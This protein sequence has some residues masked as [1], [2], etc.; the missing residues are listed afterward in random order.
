MT[1]LN[2]IEKTPGQYETGIESLAVT[3]PSA[4]RKLV[5]RLQNA[6][7][8]DHPVENFSVIETHISWVILTGQYVYKMKKPVNFGFL[9]FST[10]ERRKYYCHE[11]L[12]LNRRFA[13][14]LYLAV[15]PVYGTHEQPCLDTQDSPPVEYLVKM[16]Q[17]SQSCLLDNIAANKNLSYT[18]VDNMADV[19]AK[20]HLRATSAENDSAYGT[21]KSVH[22]WVEENFQQ[23]LPLQ[24]DQQIIDLLT[25][26]HNWSIRERDRCTELIEARR[27]DGYV[28]ECHGDLHLGNMT[29][30]DDQITAFDCLEFNAEL[31]FIDVINEAAFVMM[32]LQSRGYQHFAWRFINRYLQYTGD[33]SGVSMLRY[34]LAY[35][36]MVRAKVAALRLQQTDVE[37]H[38]EGGQDHT[39]TTYTE[40]A[41]KYSQDYRPILILMHGLSGSGKSTLA[42]QIAEVFGGFQIRSDVERKRL[43]EIDETSLSGSGLDSGIY[44][45][46]ATLQTYAHLMRMASAIVKAGYPAIIDASFLEYSRRAEFRALAD[47]LET[48]CILIDCNAPEPVLR[49][50]VTQRSSSGKDASEANT[51]V[52][53]RQLQTQ[54]LLTDDENKTVISVDTS[55]PL[56]IEALLE[57]LR[58]R[59][60]IQE[61]L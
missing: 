53:E 16:R 46:K 17:F 10:V 38:T 9:D 3:S 55:Q 12:R 4:S 25:A 20:L 41:K 40:L 48:A 30:I 5:K 11:E 1:L 24:N 33:Y 32:D 42:K 59:L 6:A 45:H 21:L 26:L 60:N 54:D 8:Y 50:R 36:A 7:L 37:S 18:H 52:L 39:F 2:P 49:K 27:Q 61:A 19:V 35:R 34:Y 43:F 58:E 56:N 51:Q 47:T 44:T 14:A 13:P 22:H 15:V 57:Y 29:L 28:R 31:R 23:I